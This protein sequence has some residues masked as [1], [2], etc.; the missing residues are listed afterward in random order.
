MMR[1]Q[2]LKS[3]SFKSKFAVGMGKNRMEAVLNRLQATEPVSGCQTDIAL[4]PLRP[5]HSPLCP[6]FYPAEIYEKLDSFPKLLIF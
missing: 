4:G 3:P 2:A 1:I 5:K 6:A